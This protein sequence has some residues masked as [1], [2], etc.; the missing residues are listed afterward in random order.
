MVMQL[1]S[2]RYFGRA[3]AT[4][5]ST[6]TRRFRHGRTETIRSVTGPSREFCRQFNCLATDYCLASANWQPP[7]GNHTGGPSA[8]TVARLLQPS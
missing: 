8:G 3:V 6:H 1:A 2:Y 5:E 4:Y 7:V